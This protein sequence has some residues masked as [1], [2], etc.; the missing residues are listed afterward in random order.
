MTRTRRN[1]KAIA[2]PT[3]K[4]S[5]CLIHD[6]NFSNSLSVLSLNNVLCRK[7][8]KNLCRK[9][10]KFFFYYSYR[11]LR[12]KSGEKHFFPWVIFYSLDNALQYQIL[13]DFTKIISP[14]ISTYPEKLF[15]SCVTFWRKSCYCLF[16]KI[17]T[18]KSCIHITPKN[19][20]S[21]PAHLFAVRGSWNFLKN[22]F[23]DKAVKNVYPGKHFSSIFTYNWC[24]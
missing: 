16:S 14:S 11:W 2:K 6:F 5:W 19:A 20:N 4:T 24:R 7:I 22:C 15:S 3:Q 1:R 9:L 23:G 17:F 10:R 13:G 21:L 12:K 8:S 18:K